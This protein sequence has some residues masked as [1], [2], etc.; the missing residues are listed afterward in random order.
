MRDI[1][2]AFRDDS[3]RLLLSKTAVAEMGK[4]LWGR[5][6][7]HWRMLWRLS[8]CSRVVSTRSSRRHEAE[9]ARLVETKT[10]R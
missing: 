1:E 9:T 2:D 10:S 8:F 6:Q 5:R 7:G 4:Q 3:G